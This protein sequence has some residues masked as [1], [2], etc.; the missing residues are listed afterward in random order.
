MA[1][2]DVA[3][4]LFLVANPLSSSTRV[5]TFGSHSQ[6]V[7]NASIS[8]G[9]GTFPI[10][11][12]TE[13]ALGRRRA[14]LMNDR[15]NRAVQ[16]SHFRGLGGGDLQEICEVVQLD[17]AAHPAELFRHRG[18]VVRDLCPVFHGTLQRW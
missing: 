9:P 18:G 4:R 10:S 16:C 6:C 13:T 15:P 12:A 7:S 17:L 11:T 14:Q 1:Y 5:L 8:A 3:M 2:R